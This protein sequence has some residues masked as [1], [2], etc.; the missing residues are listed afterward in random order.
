MLGML[1]EGSGD[2]PLPWHRAPRLPPVG[3]GGAG[4]PRARATAAWVAIPF[5]SSVLEAPDHQRGD[6]RWGR[7]RQFLL[8]WLNAAVNRLERAA[9]TA[10]ISL[11]AGYLRG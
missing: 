1:R 11:L 10:S 6:G 9:F 7:A 5:S 4:K 8:R 2:R 3:Q